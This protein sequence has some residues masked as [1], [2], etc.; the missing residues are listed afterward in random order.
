MSHP[1]SAPFSD[2]GLP[3][4]LLLAEH[5]GFS[6]RGRD[7]SIFVVQ[8]AAGGVSP[9]ARQAQLARFRRERR[10]KHF[11]F[12]SRTSSRDA[13]ADA[14][15]H[16]LVDEAVLHPRNRNILA[17]RRSVAMIV[18]ARYLMSVSAILTRP[19]QRSCTDRES[20]GGSMP[21]LIVVEPWPAF[22]SC[23]VIRKKHRH[24]SAQSCLCSLVAMECELGAG[25]AISRAKRSSP[26]IHHRDQLETWTGDRASALLLA[27]VT[28]SPARQTWERPTTSGSQGCN[29]DTLSQ[30]RS[31]TVPAL[32][33]HFGPALRAC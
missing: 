30:S 11:S 16:A 31:I 29:N 9:I 24:V 28:N 15:E 6:F 25:R 18:L 5:H 19:C 10:A 12:S 13:V 22:Y 21:F 14:P 17:L 33:P 27:R 20:N 23:Y 4:A 32:E 2:D 1:F 3:S 8:T 7:K 26:D